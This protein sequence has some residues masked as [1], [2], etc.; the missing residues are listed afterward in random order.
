MTICPK[1]EAYRGYYIRNS[2][3]VVRIWR[4][5][6]MIWYGSASLEEAKALIDEHIKSGRI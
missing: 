4:L 5:G 3:I 1:E 6:R 2:G